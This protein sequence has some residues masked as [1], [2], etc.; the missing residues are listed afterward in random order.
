[1]AEVFAACH[2]H[3]VEPACTIIFGHPDET[4]ADMAR[5]VEMV[6]EVRAAYTEFHVMVLIPKTELFD[7]AVAE[8]KV[9]PDVFDRFM[10]GEVGYPEYAPGDL[11]A[12]DMRSIHQRAIR[13]FYFRPEYIAQALGR[14]RRPG[15]LL[16]YAR[17]ARSLF[18]MSDLQRPVWSLGRRRV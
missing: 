13:D 2:R 9:E 16:Q 17:A 4:R 1:M 7:R 12:A 18:S 6:K 8:G 5:S 14:V 10:R 3:G 11:T 15:D